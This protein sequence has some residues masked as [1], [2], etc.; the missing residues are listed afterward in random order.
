MGKACLEG[1]GK[2]LTRY[3]LDA[4]KTQEFSERDGLLKIRC[5]NKT[6]G[7]YIKIK[8]SD[9]SPGEQ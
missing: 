4:I 7:R 9:L 1:H 3:I 8:L 5:N 2:P 6:P